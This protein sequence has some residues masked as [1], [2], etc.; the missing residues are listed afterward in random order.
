[1]VTIKYCL[2]AVMLSDD[3]NPDQPYKDGK[4]AQTFLEEEKVTIQNGKTNLR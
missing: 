2:I 4:S 1:M 3:Q